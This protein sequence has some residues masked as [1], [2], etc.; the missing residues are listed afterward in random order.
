MTSHGSTIPL[1]LTLTVLALG[2][3]RAATGAEQTTTPHVAE[4]QPWWSRYP[5]V[6]PKEA[7]PR[8]QLGYRR[9]ILTVKPLGGPRR[10]V[11]VQPPDDIVL[12]RGERLPDGTCTRPRHMGGIV[13]VENDW[14]GT[15]PSRGSAAETGAQRRDRGEGRRRT[16]RRAP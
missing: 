3:P 14:E 13:S 7:V 2:V 11:V 10:R 6:E 1:A 15:A 8:S 9:T 5:T 12:G 16:E 4:S